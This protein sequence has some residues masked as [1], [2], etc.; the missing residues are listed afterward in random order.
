M[1]RTAPLVAAL[2]LAAVLA[3]AAS[4]ASRPPLTQASSGK[5]IHLAKGASATLRLSN[6]WHWS[7]PR[8]TTKAVELTLVEYLVDPG[9]REWTIDARK[10]GRATIRSIG[11]PNCTTCAL[12]TRR[13]ALTI[14]VG[15][16]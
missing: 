4:A 10:S 5:T 16:S 1:T 9:F 2:G 6:R 11:R 14:V 8:I 12:A 15:S 3:V 13:F 7:E